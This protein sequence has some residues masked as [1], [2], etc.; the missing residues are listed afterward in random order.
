[1]SRSHG[2]RMGARSWEHPAGSV[3]LNGNNDSVCVSSDP[4]GLPDDL[5]EKEEVELG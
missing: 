3:V 1:M 5:R 2:G 4:M